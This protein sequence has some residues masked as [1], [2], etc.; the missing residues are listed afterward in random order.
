MMRRLC[1]LL[2]GMLLLPTLIFATGKGEAGQ[3]SEQQTKVLSY[4]W[5][6]DHLY[7]VYD[8]VINDFAA[9]KGYE[10][11][12]QVLNWGE[13]KTKITADFTAGTSP[14]LIEVPSPWIAEFASKG[15][16]KDI[17]NE[18]KGHESYSDFFES[19]WTEVSYKDSL[20]G[21][22]L[23]HTC[24]GLFYN[25]AHFKEAGIEPPTTL[26]ELVSVIDVID[27]KLGPEKMAFGFDPTGQYLVP[28]L[29]SEETPYLIDGD[30]SALDTAVIRKTL[31]TLQG[32]AQSG[33]VFVPDPGGE[34]TRGNVRLL[35]LTGKIS[36]M[37]SGPWEVGN[38]KKNYPDLDYGLIMVPHLDGVNAR[39]LT[40]GT[41]LAIP[42]DSKLS[43]DD[44]FELMTRLTSVDTEVA[45]TLEA[46][47]L[48]PRKGWSED[49]RV[50]GE[51]A[52]QLFS[53]VLPLA[54]PFD[55]GIRKVG[56]PELTWGG[57]VFTKMYQRMLYT[58]DSMDD[59]LDNYIREAN[60]LLK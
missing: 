60:K 27:S 31:K 51:K 57:S 25:K 16:L 52:V 58:D 46:G 8:Q 37:I 24:F 20:Y 3:E 44:I 22:K 18:I 34:D 12:K 13:F 33:K 49:P 1:I 21:M 50:Q 14:D 45:A 32:I 40:A 39:T 35:F 26:E 55:I 53:K 29:A 6:P 38:I 28:F 7:N 42:I 30:A 47:M 9:E 41:G 19:T 17:T 36:M 11:N 2:I 48:M 4:Y 15:F 10:V 5:N 43:V 59:A 54:T 23:H 56:L